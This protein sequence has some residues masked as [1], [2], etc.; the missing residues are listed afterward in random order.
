M[1]ERTSQPQLSF[2]LLPE[3]AAPPPHKTATNQHDERPAYVVSV[4]PDVITLNRT[5]NYFVS[6][7]WFED[8]RAEQLAVGSIVRIE[9][10][11]RQVQ[12]WVTEFGVEPPA[13]VPLMPL[14]HL[15]GIGP[16]ADIVE[17]AGWAAWRWAGSKV[18][19]MRTASPGRIIRSL[20]SQEMPREPTSTAK[21]HTVTVVRSHPADS[22]L[23][24]AINACKHGDALIVVPAVAAASRI[25]TGLR[26]AGIKVALGSKAWA[27]AASGGATVVG[28]CSV[29][30]M[31]IPHL[32]AVVVIDEHDATLQVQ[33]TPTWHARDVAVERARRQDV[34]L[35]LMSPVP[36][37]EAISVATKVLD[38]TGRDITHD[39]ITSQHVETS[40]H[41]RSQHKR[42]WPATIVL[43]R[44]SEDPVRGGLF[45]PGITRLL[46]MAKH[47]QRIVAVLNRKGTSRLLACNICGELVCTAN[48]STP[49][50][51]Q[52]G[53]LVA[54]DGS[55]RRPAVCALCGSTVLRNLRMGV[56]RARRDLEA[57]AR[58]PVGEL[59]SDN[60]VMP[61]QRIVIGTEAVLWRIGFTS[62][63]IFLDFDQ[64]LLAPRQRAASQALALLARAARIL[65]STT[66]IH[67]TDAHNTIQHEPKLVIQTRQ[68]YHPVVQ[69]AV[70]SDTMIVFDMEREHS[71]T[72]GLPPFAAQAKVS[73]TGAADFVH[74][75][76]SFTAVA[77]AAK[78]HT[79]NVLADSSED[80][81]SLLTI[82]GPLG[83]AYLLRSATHETLL[84]TLANAP[85][86]VERI[87]LEI[88]PQRI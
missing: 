66:H 86:P 50:I 64:E 75:L 29:V 52:D 88:D 87:R 30:W 21:K 9:L 12:G 53:E 72:F 36:S 2:N 6:A 34:P 61:D 5:F 73:G 80:V 48:G 40:V 10:G 79:T 27:Q 37:L 3:T 70:K 38:H 58:E 7:D 49:M 82:Q 23:E 1:I 47:E 28:T 42:S 69:A 35:V 57:L 56:T 54:R 68:P 84:N 19:L 26:R 15:V 78:Q 44:R 74:K 16:P 14:K 81:T 22:G 39:Y 4:L 85:P 51:L 76:K 71:R 45:S 32:S 65:G 20:P 63:V 83:G 33:K 60:D 25:A 77:Y 46:D 17:L 62:V 11:G 43:D 24:L 41:E 67:N 13:G 55:E 59:T 8:G 31:P 18:S